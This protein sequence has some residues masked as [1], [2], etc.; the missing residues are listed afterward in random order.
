MSKT[1]HVGIDVALKA[2]CVCFTDDQGKVLGTIKSVPNTLEGAAS[3]KGDICRLVEKHCVQWVRIGTEATSFYD[4]HLLEHFLAAEMPEGIT[5]TVYRINPRLIKAFKKCSTEGSKTDRIDAFFVAD[6]L[7]FKPSLP[8]YES[9]SAILPLQRLTRYRHTI[10]KTIT[11]ETNRFISSVFLHMPGLIQQQ[12]IDTYGKTIIKLAEDAFT[13]DVIATM[14]LDELTR[15]LILHSRNSLDD[16]RQTACDIQQ[17]V[18]T[19]FPV[20]NVLD[21][22]LSLIEKSMAANIQTFRKCLKTIDSEIA[23]RMKDFPNTLQTVAGIGPVYAAGI[24]AEIGDISLYSSSD[25]LAKR[26]GLVWNHRQSG[27]TAAA[28]TRLHTAANRDLRYYMIEAANSVR[29][30][31]EEYCRYYQKKYNE[32]KEH[33]HRRALVLTARKLVRLVYTLLKNNQVYLPRSTAQHT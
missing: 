12:P 3:I 10:V 14:D 21:E 1:M 30:H 19:S 5:A 26:A 9:K 33:Q 16:P 4:M 17:A 7:R 15:R 18:A 28:E 8:P 20:S 2:N 32:V 29:V 13:K 31:D 23:K 25:K 24:I 6:Y 27:E 11:A 22:T